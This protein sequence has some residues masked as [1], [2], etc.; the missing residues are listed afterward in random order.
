MRACPNCMLLN[1]R[2]GDSFAD[3]TPGAFYLDR[4]DAELFSGDDGTLSWSNDWQE[5][6]ETNGASSG[7][8]AVKD[9]FGGDGG[10]NVELKLAGD[11]SA[12]READLTG[13]MSA[14]LSFDYARLG[15]DAGD[16]LVVYAQ[17]GGGTGGVSITDAPGT[18]D[19]NPE[20]DPPSGKTVGI[21]GAGPSG[22]TAAWF[23]GRKGHK[24][25]LYEANERS[26]GML[27]YGVPASRLD[28]TVLDNDIDEIVRRVRF[29]DWQTTSAG[30]REVKKA[31][32]RTLFKYK[33]HQDA[34]LFE[35]A[36]GYIREYY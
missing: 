18:Y 7:G 12:W 27:R 32:R 24:T 5:V 35:R 26:G 36:Y 19:G 3:V 6:G 4:F 16:D 29:P 2:V 28:A 13:A 34:D 22:L 31:L 15:L 33:L 25:V 21:V 14:T 10:G 20:C 30:E 23:L 8:V 17:S 9:F 11:K 1:V